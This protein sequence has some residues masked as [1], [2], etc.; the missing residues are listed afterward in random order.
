MTNGWPNRN[1]VPHSLI[2]YY[3]IKDEIAIDDGFLTRS[4]ERIILPNALVSTVLAK[5]HTG[6][7]GI[8][9][10]KQ[11]LRET[12]WWPKQN[13]QVE[14]TV[15][16]CTGC[17]ASAKSVPPLRHSSISLPKPE[18]AWE[19]VSID[20][21]YRSIQP[22]LCGRDNRPFLGFPRGPAY[23]QNDI[24]Q[25]NPMVERYVLQVWLPSFPP[26]R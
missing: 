9:R 12:Y 19:L 13:I 7:P 4:H 26:D 25:I 3:A 21:L 2:P 23:L 8:V 11:K 16:H 5:A 22:S 18:T 15:R 17:Q 24:D 6:H 10:M 1:Q 20:I 14:E